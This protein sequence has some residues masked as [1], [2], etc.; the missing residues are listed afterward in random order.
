M[1]AAIG[2]IVTG[3]INQ[4]TISYCRFLPAWVNMNNKILNIIFLVS[5]AIIAFVVL[6]P[7]EKKEYSKDDIAKISKVFKNKFKQIE[8]KQR[9]EQK[10]RS[11][12]KD[13]VV[14]SSNN[15]HP[16]LK[17][18]DIDQASRQS[19]LAVIYKKPNFTWFFKAKDSSENIKTISASFKNY[20][21]DQL[22]FDKKNQPVFSHIPDS[23]QVENTST[24]RVATFKIGEVEISVS[25]LAGQQNVSA[26][27]QRW[28]R[29]IGLQ[30][31]SKVG[32]VYSENKQKIIVTMPN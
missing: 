20:F 22:K 14:I 18:S 2:T 12:P 9:V 27:I 31:G 17:K 32:I 16:D 29:Q 25:K 7:T 1:V 30:D 10:L 21:V 28:M 24:M 8:E 6:K 11:V 3:G 26:N 13:T 19:I 23:M 4:T 15:P 5:I